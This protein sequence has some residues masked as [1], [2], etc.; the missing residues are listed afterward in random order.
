MCHYPVVTNVTP[1]FQQHLPVLETLINE[2]DR[3]TTGKSS[4]KYAPLL[5]IHPL[6]VGEEMELVAV[7]PVSF[8]HLQ[9]TFKNNS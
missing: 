7:A 2:L 8:E 3:R 4:Q 6:L 5:T 1:G 9:K